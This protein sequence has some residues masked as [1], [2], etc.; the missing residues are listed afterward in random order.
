[1]V[2]FFIIVIVFCHV[3]IVMTYAYQLVQKHFFCCKK[4]LNRFILIY[5]VFE[6]HHYLHCMCEIM[7]RY[8]VVQ[9][10]HFNQKFV[11]FQFVHFLWA[12]LLKILSYSTQQTLIRYLKDITIYI[13]YITYIK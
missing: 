2:N 3:R 6:Y 4:L 5:H 11:Q 12:Y 8:K 1:M 10:K 7:V 9:F 13:I